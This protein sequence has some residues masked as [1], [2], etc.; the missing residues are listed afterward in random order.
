VG[1]TGKRERILG[2]LVNNKKKSMWKEV[3]VHHLKY[4]CCPSIIW[5]DEA[6]KENIK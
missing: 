3:A 5:R 2:W 4:A 6:N 1:A